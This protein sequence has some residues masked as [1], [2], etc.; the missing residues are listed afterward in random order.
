MLDFLQLHT[1]LPLKISIKISKYPKHHASAHGFYPERN[2]EPLTSF[3]Q[4]IA[5]KPHQISERVSFSVEN[6]LKQRKS[7]GL[8]NSHGVAQ[9]C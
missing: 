6:A 9:P 2:E 8:K 1:I 5:T 3:N 4:Y 7:G